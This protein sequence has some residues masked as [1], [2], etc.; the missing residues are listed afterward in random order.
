MLNLVFNLRFHAVLIVTVVLAVAIVGV[1]AT[2]TA[3][4][5]TVVVVLVVVVAVSEGR[6]QTVQ[7]PMSL[8][9]SSRGWAAVVTAFIVVAVVALSGWVAVT[10]LRG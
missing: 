8:Q 9:V 7:S 4:V 5:I 2:A 1:I 6:H 10:W 3:T